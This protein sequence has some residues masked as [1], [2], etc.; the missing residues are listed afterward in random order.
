MTLQQPYRQALSLAAVFLLVHMTVAEAQE[1]QP[2]A[3]GGLT[4]TIIDGDNAIMNVR[5]R[6]N[7]EAIVQ[8]EDENHRPVAGALILFTAPGNGPSATFINGANNISLV[9]DQQGRVALRGITPNKANGKFEIRIKA[10]KNGQT[11]V[12][13]LTMTNLLRGGSTPHAK[14]STKAIV[15][16]V[17]IAAVAIGIGI[18]VGTNGGG[19]TTPAAGSGPSSCNL[20]PLGLA[21]RVR[22]GPAQPSR[23]QRSLP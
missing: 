10:S 2:S 5:Q 18:A 15:T 21:L 6:V 20:A 12:A 3:A 14:V 22:T 17:A 13:V 9:T 23:Q 19:S 16:I 8:V 7:R 1:P 11:A 4:I